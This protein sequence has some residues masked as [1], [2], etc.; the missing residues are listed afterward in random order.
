ML[1]QLPELM[2]GSL[3]S[4]HPRTKL[5]SLPWLRFLEVTRANGIFEIARLACCEDESRRWNVLFL[6]A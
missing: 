4:N 6:A 5:M 3:F 2:K 1:D